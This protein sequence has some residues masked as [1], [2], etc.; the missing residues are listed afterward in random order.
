M[1]V[2]CVLRRGHLQLHV[3][4]SDMALQIVLVVAQHDTLNSTT[5]TDFLDEDVNNVVSCREQ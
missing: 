1:E 3:L 5:I 2:V 4:I